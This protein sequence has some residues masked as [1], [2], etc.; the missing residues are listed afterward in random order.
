MINTL[1]LISV[2][3]HLWLQQPQPKNKHLP[4]IAKQ[5]FYL[6]KRHKDYYDDCIFTKKYSVQ[7]RLKQYPFVKASSIIA[8]SYHAEELQE[9]TYFDNEGKR[10]DSNGKRI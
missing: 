7:H 5:W 1:S 2:L 8:V 4:E 6:Q 10:I 9:P 3:Y